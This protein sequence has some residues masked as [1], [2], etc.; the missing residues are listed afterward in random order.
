LKQ[1][2]RPEDIAV[3]R[4]RCFL[5]F[6]AETFRLQYEEEPDYKLLVHLLLQALLDSGKSPNKEFDW[7][8]KPLEPVNQGTNEIVDD[9]I[10]ME[11]FDEM[12]QGVDNLE[13]YFQSHKM[14]AK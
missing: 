11:S 10:S 13:Q 6:V 8:S 14:E 4:A 3:E 1:A 12:A 2:L 7:S 9:E 5:P